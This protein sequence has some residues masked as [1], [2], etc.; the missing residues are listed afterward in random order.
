M[1]NKDKEDMFNEEDWNEA[2]ASSDK[3]NF[4]QGKYGKRVDGTNKGSGWLGEL[5]MKDGSGRVM[6]EFSVGF[7]VNGEE[8]EMPVVVPT[9]DKEEI[10]YLL[11]GGEP[12]EAMYDKAFEHGM[13][14]IKE[15]KSPFK[16]DGKG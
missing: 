16:S 15:G 3:E 11:E 2:E 1:M 7:E 10:Q 5:Q 6:T 12:T 8:I 9:L 14:R 4:K 13:K